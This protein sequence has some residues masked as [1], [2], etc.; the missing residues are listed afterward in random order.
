MSAFCQGC[1]QPVIARCGEV[2][3]KHWAHVSGCECDPWHEPETEWHVHWK[4]QFEE[5]CREVVI[6]PHRADIRATR[7]T[8]SSGFDCIIEL[9][10]SPIDPAEIDERETFYLNQCGAII[11]IL[12]VR[13]IQ[14]HFEVTNE[15]RENGGATSQGSFKWKWFRR[16]WL[17]M[18]YLRSLYLDRGDELWEIEKMDNGGRGRFRSVTYHEFLSWFAESVGYDLP[19]NWRPT[20]TGGW[21]YRFGNGNV[22]M[23]Q[24]LDGWYQF[25]VIWNG[26]DRKPGTGKY[27]TVEEAKGKCEPHL[28]KLMKR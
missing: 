21:V 9:Q 28:T 18:T 17:G 2:N 20:S 3:E 16:S 25:Q 24:R 26:G 15:R 11:W 22:Q 27:R 19:V 13:G 7:V 12:D 1:R 14:D 23:F 10:H 5:R 6:A 4:M 8:E